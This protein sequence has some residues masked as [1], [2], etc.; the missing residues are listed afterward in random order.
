MSQAADT[1]GSDV[2]ICFYGERKKDTIICQENP[3]DTCA[4][5]PEGMSTIPMLLNY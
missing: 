3:G 2:F 4:W 5:H 1:E